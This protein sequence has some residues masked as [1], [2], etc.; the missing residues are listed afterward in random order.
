MKSNF[1]SLFSLKK[2]ALALACM[3][4][5]ANAQVLLDQG[6]N[7]S[8][9]VADYVGTGQN[10]FDFIG[11]A[12]TGGSSV[13][14]NATSGKLQFQRSGPALAI[15]KSTN[16]SA[17]SPTTLRISFKLNS[18]FGTNYSATGTNAIFY[19]GNTLFPGAA[20]TGEV[21]TTNRHSSFG[22]T[23][24]A[25]VPNTCGGSA[26]NT[27]EYYLRSVSTV[28]VVNS[29]TYICE[30]E[31][32]WFINNS[33]AP[34]TYADMAGGTS[35]LPDDAADIWVG[36]TRVYTA[37]PAVNPAAT[38]DN[39]KFLFNN[40]DGAV[41]IDDVLITTGNEALPVA[42]SN[43]KASMAGAANKVSWSTVAEFNNKGF[44]VERQSKNGTW[45]SLGF[46]AGTNKAASYSFKDE[47]PLQVSNYR[48]RQVDLDG[49]VTYSSVVSV[50][51]EFKDRITI[52]PNPA[53]NIVT[54]DISK[55]RVGNDKATVNLY[56]FT[57]RKILTQSTTT[58]TLQ[59]NLA[60]LPKGTYMMNILCDNMTFNEKLIKQ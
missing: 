15:V 24:V 22:L 46:V 57:G 58:G 8:T 47:R 11:A 26:V 1:T 16:L 21:A 32:N 31:I 12:T 5:L 51:Q 4:L 25:N 38:L 7:S 30:R 13:Y 44:Y 54:V 3:P 35:T 17:T 60:N 53:T 33:G 29:P 42:F 55:L 52:A 19:V 41:T 27:K 14:F 43:L 18:V 59:L 40:G 9:V 10:Q 6:F 56:D 2:I 20:T 36:N 23:F 39:F 37:I 34:I 50:K 45:E 49:K 48:L 28:P